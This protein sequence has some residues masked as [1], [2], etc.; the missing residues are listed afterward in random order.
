MLESRS[1]NRS[2]DK[3]S[4]AHPDL[5]K[6]E[7]VKPHQSTP[8]HESNHAGI[9]MTY[10]LQAV[11]LKSDVFQTSISDNTQLKRNTPKQ[12]IPEYDLLKYTY[13]PRICSK[14][15]DSDQQSTSDLFYL[16][17]ENLKFTNRKTTSFK[18]EN[19]MVNISLG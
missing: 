19:P 6:S 18:S 4:L 2:H 5:V 7:I 9:L 14:P 17:S 8:T 1:N 11:H 3:G 13:A 15:P 16:K 10:L 12:I